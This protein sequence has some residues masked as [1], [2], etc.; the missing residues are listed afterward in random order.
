M[1]SLCGKHK[2]VKKM[3][4]LHMERDIP[5]VGSY[6]V[7]VCG[8]GPAGWVAAV[9]AARAGQKTAL[10]ERFG[11]LGGTATAGFIVPI[12]GFHFKGKRVVGGIAW[13]FIERLEKLGAALPE[14]PAGH[15]SVNLE[16]YK[17]VAEQMAVEA[18]V[19]LYT[20]A[21]LTD[22]V[23]DGDRV[24]HAVFASKNGNEAVEGKC[25][26]DATGDGDLCYMAGVPMMQANEGL[27]PVS[28]CFIIT[29]VDT[30]T[31]LLRDCIHHDGKKGESCNQVIR[32]M[33]LETA[34]KHGIAQF[35]GPWF[36]T[37]LKGNSL[38]VNVTRAD[39]DATDRAAY[40]QAEATLRADMFRLVESMREEYAEFRNC[41]IVISGVNAGIRETRH[42]KGV[43]TVT[44]Q[45]VLDG[46]EFVCP[47]AHCAHPIDIHAAKGAGQRL[48]GL[49]RDCYVPHEA[50][51]VQGFPNLIAA[52]RCIS[53][54]K[55]P[56]ASLRVQA[57]VMSIGE[58]AGVMA[59]LFCTLGTPVYDL[60]T[61][62]LRELC[63]ERKF[64]L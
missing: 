43:R 61:D 56:Y 26:I 12:S 18:G 16:Y 1:L 35:G 59:D 17:T 9:S 24:T 64:V 29:G 38:A 28:L 7:V 44:A 30:D 52:G 63:E 25:F 37:L 49:K 60:P 6:D 33:L 20:N 4:K 19:V 11:F 31:D 22:C 47:V 15:V 32:S 36:N 42:I 21:Y 55:E 62:R 57:T 40:T 23:M 41:E 27:Q 51:V 45:D 10:I 48:T 5:V 8:G 2:E 3:I 14:M 53:A 54:E 13:E 39:V 34:E 58:A 50:M 46:T